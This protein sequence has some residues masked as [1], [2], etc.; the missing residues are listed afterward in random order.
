VHNFRSD[1]ADKQT[2]RERNKP[3]LLLTYNITPSA[4]GVS[5]FC[6]KSHW[7]NALKVQIITK[8]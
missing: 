2:D 3:L 6:C 1:A 8:L 4:G 5:T 7:E